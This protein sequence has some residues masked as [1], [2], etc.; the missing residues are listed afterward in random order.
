MRIIYFLILL[1]L[2]PCNSFSQITVEKPTDTFQYI[3]S[4]NFDAF[5]Q[6]NLSAQSGSTASK[7]NYNGLGGNGIGIIYSFAPT[8]GWFDMN[9][10]LNDTL[11]K[12]YPFVFFIRSLSQVS[13]NLEIKFTDKDGSVFRKVVP[14]NNFY[15]DWH[16]VTVYLGDTEY[17][18][19]GDSKFDAFARFSIAAS[20]NAKDTILLDEIGIG[21][22]N[23]P[24]SFA[25]V[26]DPDSSLAGTGFKQRRDAGINPEDTLVLEY[27]RV[28][29]DNSSP[30]ADLLPSQE[31][32][33]AQTFNNCLAAMSFITKNDKER[34][35]R[36]LDFYSN[37]TNKSNNDITLQ[38][39]YYNG[40]ARG[41][42]QWV[43]LDSRQAPAG[44][45][46]RWIGDMAW[47]LI[48]CKYYEK[49]YSSDKYESLIKLIK[50]LMISYYKESEYG[51]FIQSGWRKGDSYLHEPTGHHEGN[52]DCYVALKLCGEN[53]YAQK[54]KIW[55]EHQ[56]NNQKNLPLDLY[57]WR[58]LAFGSDYINLLNI[59]D[60][61]FSYRKILEANG[62]PTMGFYN[63][64]DYYTNN[65]WNDGTGHIACAYQSYG[66]KERGYFYANQLDNL[67]VVR[68]IGGKTVH[69]V[70]YTLNKS[71]GYAWV[72][73]TKGFVSSC[74]WY[75]LAKNG[76]NPFM[77]ENFKDTILSVTD[78]NYDAAS[79]DL[80]PNPFTSSLTTSFHLNTPS[81]I[82]IEIYDMRG[83]LMQCLLK[84]Q[85]LPGSYSVSWNGNNS[86]GNTV[87]SGIYL[88]V[89]EKN[90]RRQT[91][92][93][94]KAFY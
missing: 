45:C 33:Q 23:L 68:E 59:P 46:D 48:S 85:L 73:T 77:S 25:S 32:N 39:F 81:E 50:D 51:G 30:G 56:L 90:G 93:V 35:E 84:Q 26:Y 86:C 65:F 22:K 58:V 31:D 43:N 66:E 57:T 16:H 13:D 29:Q 75:I 5:V 62:I 91:F 11:Q 52:I 53:F 89:F 70:P 74:A 79:I 36:I 54:I 64:S 40:E 69:A 88:L 2:W 24:S 8:G 37:A 61:N 14:V 63:T 44:Q 3:A 21:K 82:G 71:A 83:T 78:M 12:E 76:V 67:I 60:F 10:P 92:K 17:A 94:H 19:G 7:S 42:Y 87:T 6:W 27:L 41:F 80:F 28:L 15:G 49:V 38:N 72:D 9:I 55:L 20:G 4:L 18:W 47:L 34:A 1:L